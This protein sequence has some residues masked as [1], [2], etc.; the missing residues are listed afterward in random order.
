MFNNGTNPLGTSKFHVEYRTQNN[1]YKNTQHVFFRH[2]VIR[3]CTL[4][5]AQANTDD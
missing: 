1:E 2:V 4:Y 5:D 3:P